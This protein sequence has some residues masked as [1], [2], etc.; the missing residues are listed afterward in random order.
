MLKDAQ[1]LD[2]TT[3]SSKAIAAI[4]CFV[5][6]S[7][8][9]GQ[10]AETAILQGIAADPTC[11]IA[12]AYAAAHYLSQEN[13]VAWR[14]AKPHLKVA[15]KYS[16]QTSKR[17]QL[18][19]QAIAAWANGAI[20]QAIVY[21]EAIAQQFPQDLLSVQQGQ[22]HY[23]YRGDKSGLLEIALR[24]LPANQE[25]AY[26]YGMIAFG[27]EQHHQLPEAEEIGRQATAMNRYNPWAHHA[28]AHVMEMQGRVD[29]G[30]AWMERLSDTWEQ[31]NSM[32]HTH[33]WWHVGLYYLA[34]GD[35]QKVLE[36]Y[37][38]RV[39]GRACKASP[40]DQVGAIAL[41]LRL[42]LKG[43]SVG[44][45]WQELGTYLL[46]RIHEHKLPFQDLHY[47]Y[48]LARAGQF[49]YVNAMLLS[50]ETHARTLEPHTRKTWLEVALP[51]AKG[52]VA[53]AYGDYERAIAQL[54]PI[55]SDLWKVGGSHAQ[56]Q[57]F[58]QIYSDA[59]LQAEQRV[60]IRQILMS[61]VNNRKVALTQ[62]EPALTN[63]L[64]LSTKAS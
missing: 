16:G 56:R 5:E 9:Y 58:S 62:G 40:K 28:V 49:N 45:Y 15:K 37:N 48:A 23:F 27:L 11:A 59:L 7:F 30:I 60:S 43:L 26:L 35:M 14:Q 1:G 51:A 29:E 46:P 47:V 10:D 52:V 22:Y 64:A 50:M 41:L 13:V 55:L 33:N 2:T 34:K 44:D 21:H 3:N 17:E 8:A 39:W 19:I 53:Y 12:H 36:L 6:Q 24:V 63:Q 57:L 38:S 18:F 61:P 20:D 25:N 54:K 42:E 31:C 4:N 32:L